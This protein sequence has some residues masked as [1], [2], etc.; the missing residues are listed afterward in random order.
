MT[1]IPLLLAPNWPPPLPPRPSPF[2]CSPAS[3]AAFPSPL[4]RPAPIVNT[5]Q[6]LRSRWHFLHLLNFCVVLK[7]NLALPQAINQSQL[8]QV[9]RIKENETIIQL[10]MWFRCI[11]ISMAVNPPYE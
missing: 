2:P 3:P 4:Q 1:V 6:R 10:S 5:K 11:Y 7:N 8:I 9:N